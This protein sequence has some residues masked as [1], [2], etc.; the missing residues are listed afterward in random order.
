MC[1]RAT[2][3]LFLPGLL[4][5]RAKLST[6]QSTRSS[7]RTRI[8][9]QTSPRP[10]RCPQANVPR[11]RLCG[12]VTPDRITDARYEPLMKKFEDGIEPYGIGEINVHGSRPSPFVTFAD[13]PKIH[14][15][16]DPASSARFPKQLQ[17]FE[18]RGLRISGRAAE[19]AQLPLKGV[20]SVR[21]PFAAGGVP[22]TERW[23]DPSYSSRAFRAPF[24]RRKDPS[25]ENF[26]RP[27]KPLALL[28]AKSQRDRVALS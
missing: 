28:E 10:D 25:A 12:E 22:G 9:S 5:L 19:P 7:C 18:G 26:A 27:D 3:P 15:D 11:M 23:I 2:K 6:V 21:S 20:E 8:A 24:D 16:T 1:I 4:T 14:P 17:R 13:R